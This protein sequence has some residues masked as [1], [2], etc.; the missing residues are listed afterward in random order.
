MFL[1]RGRRRAQRNSTDRRRQPACGHRNRA[2]A[3]EQKL[4][5]G[6]AGARQFID[7]LLSTSWSSTGRGLYFQANQMRLDYNGHTFEA[8]KAQEVMSD[9]KR[10][11]TQTISERHGANGTRCG[12][13]SGVR[14]RLKKACAPNDGAVSLVLFSIQPADSMNRA[15]LARWL[16]LLMKSKSQAN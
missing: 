9:H 12:L 10:A 5:Q 4:R 6:R 14:L 13:A 15:E 1:P 2:K 11:V 3:A 7:F 8:S 16:R